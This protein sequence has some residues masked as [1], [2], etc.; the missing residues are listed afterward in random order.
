MNLPFA[1]HPLVRANNL[2][3]ALQELDRL[4]RPAKFVQASKPNLNWHVNG[5]SIGRIRLLAARIDGSVTLRSEPIGNVLYLF[6]LQS[7]TG[8]LRCRNEETRFGPGLGAIIEPSTTQILHMD[9]AYET[10]NLAIDQSFVADTL[11]AITGIH[12]AKPVEFEN[13]FDPRRPYDAELMRLVNFLV[14]TLDL[15]PSPLAHPLILN[16]LQNALV[17]ALLLLHPHNHGNILE[18]N[19]M[20]ASARAV[21]RVEAYLDANAHRPITMTELHEVAGMSLRSVQA[22]FKAKRA[23]PPRNFFEKGVCSWP[24]KGSKRQTAPRKSPKWLIHAGSVIWEGSV[25]RMQ[26]VSEKNLPIP[27]TE[28]SP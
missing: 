17:S 16:N 5:L 26:S 12:S 2:D 15:D 24:K 1:N 10:L 22:G 21:S 13:A 23:V 18:S 3:D 20:S 28:S 4:H 11:T 9:S 8:W 27:C 25:R 6:L 14:T 7:G 19:T